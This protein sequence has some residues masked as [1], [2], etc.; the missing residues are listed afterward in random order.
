MSQEIAVNTSTL[1]SDTQDLQTQLD[2]VK[3]SMNQMYDAMQT[4]DAMW[5][6][7]A[8]DAFRAQFSKDQSDMGDLCE[9][10]QKIINCMT[11]AK[12]E[13]NTCERDVNGIISSIRV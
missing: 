2:A 6:G 9:T 13:Y 10:I 1:A 3:R 7:P 12:D 5:D 11:Y 4:L 8:N